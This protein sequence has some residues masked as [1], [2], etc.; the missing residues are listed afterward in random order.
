[1]LRL[2]PRPVRDAL[3]DGLAR[4]RYRW[5]GRRDECWLPTPDLRRRFLDA[6]R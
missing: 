2:V 6:A 5:F 3:Y 4:R 1:V